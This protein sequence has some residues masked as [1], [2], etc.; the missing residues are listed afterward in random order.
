MVALSGDLSL[1]VPMVIMKIHKSLTKSLVTVYVTM[2]LFA[3]IVSLVL[4]ANNTEP[5]MAT[6]LYAAMLVVFVGING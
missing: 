3:A 1:V 2:V 5:V 4:R 6:A